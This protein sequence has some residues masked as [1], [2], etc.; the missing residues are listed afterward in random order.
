MRR[1]A[2]QRKRP[3]EAESRNPGVREASAGG[4][5]S[6]GDQDG[7]VLIVALLMLILL[8]VIGI[9]ASTISSV[10]IQVAGN[11][12]FYKT[13]FYAADGGTE[14]GSELLEKNID[15][16]G[17]TTSTIG[18]ATISNPNFWS[19]TQ[20]PATNDAT[21][22]L[23]VGSVGLKIWGNSTLSTGGAIQLVA[24]YEGKGKGAGG[25]GAYMVHD[26]R[27]EAT[28]KAAARATVKTKWRHLI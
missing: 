24:G 8:T 6:R 9:S 22:A 16:R 11:D 23:S 27:A 10:E 2:I 28:A 15:S 1:Q 14:A 13:A 25:S 18:S 19:Q 5:I 17:F 7:T 12:M 3:R 20:A 26:I 21:L 4:G